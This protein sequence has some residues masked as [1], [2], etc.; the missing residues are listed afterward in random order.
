MI[1]RRHLRVCKLTLPFQDVKQTRRRGANPIKSRNTAK[2]TAGTVAPSPLARSPCRHHGQWERKRRSRI[3]TVWQHSQQQLPSCFITRGERTAGRR[4][5]RP[6][7]GLEGARCDFAPPVGTVWYY[8]RQENTRPDTFK[9]IY[10]LNFSLPSPRLLHCLC[11]KS[12]LLTAFVLSYPAHYFWGHGRQSVPSQSCLSFHH[13]ETGD[14][15]KAQH[16][17]MFPASHRFITKPLHVSFSGT[18]LTLFEKRGIIYS[19][20]M[21]ARVLVSFPHSTPTNACWLPCGGT[22]NL[23]LHW[24]NTFHWKKKKKNLICYCYYL[25]SPESAQNLDEWGETCN[26]A[27]IW[28]RFALSS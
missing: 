15:S 4:E 6:L 9:Y 21:A 22:Q 28:M 19:F 26:I 2:I 7:R 24:V 8:V 5:F 3:L 13:R 20:L 16:P 17:P 27:T 12:V 10:C 23:F 14:G 1:R 11:W 18:A 25:Y